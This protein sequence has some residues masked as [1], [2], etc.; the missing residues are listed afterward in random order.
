MRPQELRAEAR[1]LHDERQVLEGVLVELDRIPPAPPA[2]PPRADPPPCRTAND[3]RDPAWF[4][5]WV[6]ARMPRAMG[7]EPDLPAPVAAV[8]P[9]TAEA[10]NVRRRIATI[11]ARLTT[12]NHE[13]LRSPR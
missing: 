1:A 7:A 12:I 9:I 13:I 11:N 10:T 2:T 4:A 8:D 6:A 3:W 5:A